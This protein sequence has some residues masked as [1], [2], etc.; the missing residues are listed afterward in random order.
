MGAAVIVL[1]S[2]IAARH[3]V[4]FWQTNERLWRHALDTGNASY[5][6]H[7]NLGL[8]LQEGGD[9]EGAIPHYRAALEMRPDFSEA[10]NN[11]AVALARRGQLADAIAQFREAA[12]YDPDQAAVHRNLGVLLAQ[13]GDTVE[14]IQHLRKALRLDPMFQDAR[15][16]LQRL[17]AGR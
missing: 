12:R 2:A 8:A 16:D 13:Q 5:V 15:S 9:V 7:T 6:A 3:Q 10:R 14:A 4:T 17:E 11:L 1:V